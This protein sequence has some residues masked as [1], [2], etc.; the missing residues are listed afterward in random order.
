MPTTMRSLRRVVERLFRLT[1]PVNFTFSILSI[2]YVLIVF[3]ENP[4]T[5]IDDYDDIRIFVV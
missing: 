1:S 3:Q 5:S 4:F 2:S